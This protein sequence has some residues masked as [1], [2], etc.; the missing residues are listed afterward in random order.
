MLSGVERSR[1]KKR[2]LYS[3]NQVGGKREEKNQPFEIT[4]RVIE[5][6]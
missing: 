4:N 6:V 3:W 2:L 5:Q 1:R